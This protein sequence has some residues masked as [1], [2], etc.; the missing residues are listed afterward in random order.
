M[1]KYEAAIRDLRFSMRCTE[2]A[3]KQA[4]AFGSKSDAALAADVPGWREA[5]KQREAAIALLEAA[6][7]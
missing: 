2:S 3:I 5:Q 1:N 7:P 4:E 6:S